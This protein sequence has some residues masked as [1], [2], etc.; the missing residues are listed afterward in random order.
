MSAQAV[1][2]TIQATIALTNTLSNSGNQA[3]NQVT[4]GASQIAVSPGTGAGQCNELWSQ[5]INLVASTPQTLN[6]SS[7]TGEGG[8]A[9]SFSAV[10]VFEV[11]NNDPTNPVT[12]GNAATTP[13]A[14]FW[15][16]PANTE[17]VPGGG[18]KDQSGNQVGTPMLKTNL[19]AAGW[20]VGANNLLKLDPGANAISVTVT[21]AGLA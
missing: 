5:T 3:K 16:T 21:I 13:F 4:V 19:T 9:V 12:V 14:P 18:C 1:N 7:L 10:K 17:S 6:L 15:N 20:T 8:R 2:G 11:L